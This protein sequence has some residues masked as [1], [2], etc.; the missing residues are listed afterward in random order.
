MSCSNCQLNNSTN[1]SNRTDMLTSYDWLSDL[2][3]TSHVSDIVEVRFKGTRKEFYKNSNK[4]KLTRGD[5]VVV[6]TSGGHDVGIVSL[7]GKL[8][9][10][11]FDIKVKF[12]ERHQWHIIYRNASE[13]DI[14]Y[15]EEAKSREKP[16]MIQ[17]RQ[18][19]EQIGLDMKIGDVE[20]RGDGHKAIFYYIANGRVD[21]RQ[22]IKEYAREFQ[23]KVEMKQIGARQEAARVGGIGSCGRELC[24]SSW[25]TDFTSIS[26]F[27]ASKQGLSPNAE[28]LAGRCG[29]LKCCLMYELD[30]YLEAREDFPT[31]LLTLETSSGIAS[32]IKTDI[33]LKKITYKLDNAKS[34]QT[35]VLSVD[36]VKE[37]IQLN[38]RG[39]KPDISQYSESESVSESEEKNMFNKNLIQEKKPALLKNKRRNKK[40]GR[41]V[42]DKYASPHQK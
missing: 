11:Q 42:R 33:L 30:N 24:C 12:K 29:K 39:I 17:A 37:V 1:L 23:I 40:T 5:M 28:K 18:I 8:A 7:T 22:L 25:R 21:F 3:D 35:I 20:F 26:A 9:Q 2:P 31:E 15:W 36:S 10:K 14:E 34:R 13:R 38:K 4:I 32:H 16:V 19:A 41:N 6:A 27:S